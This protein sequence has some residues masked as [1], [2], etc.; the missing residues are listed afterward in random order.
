MKNILT[1]FLI[2]QI[3]FLSYQSIIVKH[4]YLDRINLSKIADEIL[5]LKFTQNYT[6]IRD[7][8]ISKE[9]F[10]I[11]PGEPAYK[12]FSVS[13][14]RIDKSGGNLKEIYKS[15]ENN[16]IR[17]LGFDNE[18]KTLFVGHNKQIISID[19]YTNK[20]ILEKNID[21]NI[22]RLRIFEKKLYVAGYRLTKDHEIYYLDTYDSESLNFIE[23]K[24]EMKYPIQDKSFRH[25][26]FSSF[27]DELF[28]SMGKTNEIYTSKDGFKNPKISFEN[29]Y[30]NKP[31][32]GNILFSLNQGLIGKFAVTSFKYLNNSY[33]FFY[34]MKLGIQYLSKKGE[35]SGLYDDIKNSGFYEPNMTNINE[36]MFSS[37][38][39][40]N[41]EISLAIF[42]IKS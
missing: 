28:L 11:S 40:K 29:T 35:N 18:N 25:P 20:I 12:G 7:I 21:K 2:C 10:F 24:K 32:S 14:V 1:L 17:S 8:I 36:F 41:D 15:K 22:L 6:T 39:N 33:I 38:K 3:S 37:K 23:T 16:I 19:T 5:I 34:D 26:T 9:Y 13:V 27:N 31:E 4:V 42:K 30:K